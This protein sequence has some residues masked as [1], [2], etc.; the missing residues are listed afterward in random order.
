L[1]AGYAC[2]VA[3]HRSQLLRE[4][5]RLE[6]VE[7]SGRRRAE[8][9]RRAGAEEV[10]PG[11]VQPSGGDQGVLALER[12]A[13]ERSEVVE[14]ETRRRRRRRRSAGHSR[15]RHRHRHRRTR[16]PVKSAR[17]HANGRR[18]RP[19]PGG[20][21]GLVPRAFVLP[22]SL[23]RCGGRR[24][25]AAGRGRPAL[26]VPAGA[27]VRAGEP[28]HERQELVGL[29]VDDLGRH[30]VD[31]HRLPLLLLLLADLA[32][33]GVHAEGPAA[34]AVPPVEARGGHDGSEAGRI[35][36]AA[37]DGLGVGVGVARRKW[38]WTRKIGMGQQD[39]N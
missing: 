36:T 18:R 7:E 15:G 1:L 39:A 6:D 33:R 4:G 13:A 34:P 19:V 24:A 28:L 10:V 20:G 21:G 30:H 11:V 37:A 29:D 5:Q 25:A 12:G 22:I 23:P 31:D 35:A 14:H 32:R 16:G 26:P 17:L 8:P 3:T 38:K 27:G 9:G 2:H